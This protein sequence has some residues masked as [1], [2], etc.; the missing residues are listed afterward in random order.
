MREDLERAMKQTKTSF[1]FQK[2]VLEKVNDM[3]EENE[4]VLFVICANMN[5]V[6]KGVHSIIKPMELKNK[7]SGVFVITTKRVF[8]YQKILFQVKYEQISVADINSVEFIK[9]MIFSVLRISANTK[10]MELDI[11]AVDG[12][13]ALNIANKV[14]NDR[15]SVNQSN[16]TINN[17]QGIKDKIKDLKELLDDGLIDEKT[18]NDKKEELLKNL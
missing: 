9:G 17:S 8:H 11:G 12:K 3:F 4:E 10:I 15:G 13:L 2:G 18:F 14:V 7:K 6:V 1:I 5:L 16:V